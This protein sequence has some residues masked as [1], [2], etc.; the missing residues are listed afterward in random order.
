MLILWLREY[1]LYFCAST[2]VVV[3]GTWKLFIKGKEFS[4]RFSSRFAGAT[5]KEFVNRNKRKI[6]FIEKGIF[7]SLSLFAI[8]HVI[9]PSLLDLPNLL[10]DNYNTARVKVIYGSVQNPSESRSR[11]ITVFDLQN[12]RKMELK[13]RSKGIKANSIIY[14]KYLKQTKYAKVLDE[15]KHK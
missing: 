11:N 9:I 4:T 6:K 15:Q 3:V 7:I 14:I 10:N 1:L 12:K 5:K 2:F 8:F 13:I